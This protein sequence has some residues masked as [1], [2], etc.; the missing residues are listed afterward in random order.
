MRLEALVDPLPFLKAGYWE[1]VHVSSLVPKEKKEVPK[2]VAR[3]N[4]AYAR[5]ERGA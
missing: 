5:V 3:G 4:P 1:K 2:P